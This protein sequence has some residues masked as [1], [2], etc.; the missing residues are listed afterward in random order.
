MSVST[1]P[2]GVAEKAVMPHKA[3]GQPSG[4]DAPCLTLHAVLIP[5][6]QE[7]AFRSLHGLINLVV[8]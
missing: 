4:N 5:S 8:C 7:L 1:T 6:L 3:A 2:V